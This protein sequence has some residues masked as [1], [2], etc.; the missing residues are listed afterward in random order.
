MMT[1]ERR[2]QS[3]APEYRSRSVSTTGV[4]RDEAVDV[5]RSVRDAGGH[6]AQTAAGEAKTIVDETTT[7]GRNLLEEGRQQ[8]RDQAVS[9]Q[10]R[11]A[12][13]LTTIAD[14]LQEIAEG[15][16]T[17]STM[18]AVARGGAEQL[19][20]L[21]SWL[22]TREPGEV[23]EEVRAFARRRPGAF[24]LGAA[25]A[26]IAVGRI[27]GAGAAVVKDASGKDSGDNV[28]TPVPAIPTQPRRYPEPRTDGYPDSDAEYTPAPTPRLAEPA[29]PPEAPCPHCSGAGTEPGIARRVTR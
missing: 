22:H 14:E 12:R 15:R 2:T 21:A 24:L 9:E 8:L 23:I 18:S 17:S 5:G 29:E 1:Q 19:Q 10:Q 16:S 27:A 4:V 26:G 13:R 3:V 25:L 7:Q 28:S 11:A 6:V 20:Q